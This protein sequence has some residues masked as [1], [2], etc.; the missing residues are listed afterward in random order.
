MKDYVLVSSSIS[1]SNTAQIGLNHD[2]EVWGSKVTIKLALANPEREKRKWL[3]YHKQAMNKLETYLE[4]RKKNKFYGLYYCVSPIISEDKLIFDYVKRV[5]ILPLKFDNVYMICGLAK[6][7]DDFIIRLNSGVITE[8]GFGILENIISASEDSSLLSLRLVSKSLN[9]I[10]IREIRSRYDKFPKDDLTEDPS[11]RSPYILLWRFGELTHLFSGVQ[12]SYLISLEKK[13]K[14][15][16]CVPLIC[17]PRDVLLSLLIKIIM[18]LQTGTILASLFVKYGRRIAKHLSL[19]ARDL[20]GNMRHKKFITELVAGFGSVNVKELDDDL[21]YHIS[22]LEKGNK[23]EKVHGFKAVNHFIIPIIIYCLVNHKKIEDIVGE[24]LQTIPALSKK[25]TSSLPKWLR[26]KTVDSSYLEAYKYGSSPSI[27]GYEHLIG[28]NTIWGI[29]PNRGFNYRREVDNTFTFL[30]TLTNGFVIPIQGTV[31]EIRLVR[32]QSLVSYKI[33][34][35]I[36]LAVHGYLGL[37]SEEVSKLNTNDLIGVISALSGED[38]YITITA[39]KFSD[40]ERKYDTLDYPLSNLI[41]R[42]LVKFCDGSH[43]F[44]PG[45]NHYQTLIKF[46]RTYP[47]YNNI[48]HIDNP[49]DLKFLWRTLKNFDQSLI[50]FSKERLNPDEVIK[51]AI[52]ALKSELITARKNQTTGFCNLNNIL[53]W[54]FNIK[55]DVSSSLHDYYKVVKDLEEKYE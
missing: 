5:R 51:L 44:L 18:K 28:M 42:I 30:L 21:Y 6:D 50:H 45:E 43:E 7:V 36:T 52:N 29:I 54:V 39:S 22:E 48:K 12:D 1:S 47:Y 41:T 31:D 46:I 20:S 16:D 38:S 26:D 15:T 8:L 49:T 3:E 23:I 37:S 24:T 13:V 27:W 2:L 33:R 53:W 55:M 4:T 19:M 35:A 10:V 25:I 34:K 40:S 32:G 14:I 11:L 9:S 17:I